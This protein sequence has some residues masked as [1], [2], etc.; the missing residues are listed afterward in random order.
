MSPE[1]DLRDVPDD[2]RRA[3][4][5]E[6][7]ADTDPGD[8]IEVVADED[9][10]GHLVRYQIERDRALGWEHARPDGVPREV[11]VTVG[12]SLDEAELGTIDVRDLKPQRRHA[13][14]LGV[15]DELDA[16]EGFVLVNDH[17]PKPLYHQFEA[18]AGPSFRWEYRQR[19][20]GKFRVLIGKAETDGTHG[21]EEEPEA[22]F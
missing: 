15:F 14:L 20:T 1:I 3:R 9:P 18:E 13:A 7:V 11:S 4:L 8:G 17:D 2:D 16:G 21:H 6:A 5:F 19:D 10:D 12:D 22:P